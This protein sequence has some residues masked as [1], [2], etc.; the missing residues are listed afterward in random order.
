MRDGSATPEVDKNAGDDGGGGVVGEREVALRTPRGRG[1]SGA[2]EHFSF[3]LEVGGT[4]Q[5]VGAFG[6]RWTRVKHRKAH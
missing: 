1:F 4:K 3:F 5:N 2:R 6:Q